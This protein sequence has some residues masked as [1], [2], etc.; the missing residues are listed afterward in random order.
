MSPQTG[1]RLFAH[2]RPVAEGG[3]GGGGGSVSPQKGEEKRKVI[4]KTNYNGCNF[5]FFPFL[6]WAPSRNEI[7]G[8][9]MTI[10]ACT[11]VCAY[12]T[13]VGCVNKGTIY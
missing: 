11:K 9:S 7:L 5:K 12:H 2:S 4:S 13:L 3:G 10:Y 1:H 8:N 6:R